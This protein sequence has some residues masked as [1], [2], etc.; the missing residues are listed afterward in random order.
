[1]STETLQIHIEKKL[2]ELEKGRDMNEVT[3][4]GKLSF[5][6]DQREYGHLPGWKELLKKKKLLVKMLWVTAIAESLMVVAI[7]GN[8]WD[9]FEQNWLKGLAYWIFVSA[10]IL[11]F[12]II[13]S[14]YTLFY[15]FRQTEREVRRIIYQDVLDR[16]Q[17]DEFE[18]AV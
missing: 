13:I 6:I 9:I 2:A 18:N 16:M 15:H 10:V 4:K 1:M 12:Q 7:I 11:F 3:L 17:K 5:G 14:Y 8:V